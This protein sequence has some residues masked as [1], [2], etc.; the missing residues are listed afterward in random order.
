MAN[1]RCRSLGGNNAEGANVI[2]AACSGSGWCGCVPGGEVEGRPARAAVGK[3]STRCAGQ[4]C[5]D[6]RPDV[7]QCVCGSSRT[8][9]WRRGTGRMGL[10]GRGFR[11]KAIMRPPGKQGHGRGRGRR[12]HCLAASRETDCTGA[13][14]ARL[15]QVHGLR[16]P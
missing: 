2:G 15:R 5:E 8:D 11:A 3:A 6:A 7:G 14:S 10:R 9:N 16:W 12:L 4:E 13:A 1:P